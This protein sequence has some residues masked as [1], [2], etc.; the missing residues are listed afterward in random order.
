MRLFFIIFIL[1]VA[2]KAVLDCLL[3]SYYK[4]QDLNPMELLFHNRFIILKS[5]I[6]LQWRQ[7]ARYLRPLA[8]NHKTLFRI[9]W[10]ISVA[11]LEMLVCLIVITLMFLAV[12]ISMKLCFSRA[13]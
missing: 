7:V 10:W 9:Y 5:T 4:K 2:C 1:L 13:V 11:C 3:Y 12:F 6:L 8:K